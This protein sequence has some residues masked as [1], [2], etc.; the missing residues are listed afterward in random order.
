MFYNKKFWDEEAKRLFE[1]TKKKPQQLTTWDNSSTRTGL[2]LPSH[3]EHKKN[4][5]ETWKCAYCC[6]VNEWE[7][8][9]CFLCGSPR[10]IGD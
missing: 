7:N 6:S 4:H 9:K 5:K 10:R 8:E 2:S 3:P 1:R